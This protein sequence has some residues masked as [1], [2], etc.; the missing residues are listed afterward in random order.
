MRWT[1]HDRRTASPTPGRALA[2][3]ARPLVAALRQVRSAAATAFRTAA[4]RVPTSLL[5]SFPG[6]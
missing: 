4:E 1:D 5:D 3:A 2:A 6:R